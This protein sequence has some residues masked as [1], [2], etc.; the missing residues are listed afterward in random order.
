MALKDL[1]KSASER[2]REEKHKRRRAFRDAERLVD[3]L[4]ENAETLKKERDKAWKEAREHLAGG[5]KFAAKSA[6]KEAR[7]CEV[8]AAKTRT[9]KSVCRTMLLELDNSQT[10]KDFQIAFGNLN[11][12]LNI[13]PGQTEDVMDSVQEKLSDSRDGQKLWEKVSQKQGEED[14]ALSLEIPSLVDMEKQLNEEVAASIGGK[15]RAHSESVSNLGD[16]IGEG[17]QRLKAL[18]EKDK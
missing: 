9:K 12:V 14:Q 17:R 4:S 16:R 10:D 3:K 5:N 15:G 8:L 7:Q 6:L 2:E 1:F 11:K 18:L 13:D